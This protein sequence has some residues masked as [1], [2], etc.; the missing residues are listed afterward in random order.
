MKKTL[1]CILAFI[2]A[3]LLAEETA[4]SAKAWKRG[5]LLGLNFTQSSY[6]NWSSGGQNSVS[7]TLLVNLFTKY[8]AEKQ[9]FDANLDLAYGRLQV[10]EE[11]RKSE[12]KIDFNAKYGLSAFGKRWFYSIIF[13]FKSQFDRGYNYPNDSVITSK[14]L[15]PAYMNYGAGLDFTPS[16]SFSVML[17]PLSAKTTMVNDKALSDAG[18]FGV[19]SGKTF[20]HEFGGSFTATLSKEIGKNVKLSTTLKLFSNYLDQP[21]NID[22]NWEMLLS[23][24]VNKYISAT[25]SA[26]LI[27]DDDSHIPY[28]KDGD[29]IKESDGP[30]TQF[31]EVLGIGFSYKF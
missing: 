5:G 7:A 21:E 6:T 18:A 25:L 27:Y 24:K 19:D 14:F 4:D 2:P 3:L 17:A 9:I 26:E 20:R 29:G 30:M 22:V 28:D 31:K 15:A 16:E 23:L 10:G 12:D 13:D 11:N 1:C 8:K